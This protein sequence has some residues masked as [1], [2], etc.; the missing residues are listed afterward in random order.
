MADQIAIRPELPIVDAASVT[1]LSVWFRDRATSAAST[2][3]SIRYRVDCLTNRKNVIT[4]TSIA[5]S[6]SATIQ[7]PGT[8]N[9]IIDTSNDS[10]TRQLLVEIDTGLSTQTRNAATWKLKNNRIYEVSVTF[11]DVLQLEPYWP[12]DALESAL[13]IEH[14]TY[15]PGHRF[16]YL[17]TFDVLDAHYYRITAAEQSAGVT[18]V[19][20]QYE[21]DRPERLGAVSDNS[22]VCTT[23]FQNIVTTN[24]HSKVRLSQGNGYLVK[25][26][27]ALTGRTQIEGTGLEAT[28]VFNPVDANKRLFYGA[29]LDN[30]L[31]RDFAINANVGAAS[32]KEGLS[33]MLTGADPNTKTVR[34][35]VDNVYF[36]SLFYSI[37]RENAEHDVIRDCR[38]TNNGAVQGG[39][40]LRYAGYLN[41]GTI[42]NCD[43]RAQ[44][45]C[46]RVVA[47][48]SITLRNN[49]TEENGTSG[50]TIGPQFYFSDVVNAILVD[51]HYGEADRTGTGD[52]VWRFDNCG[53]VILRGMILAGDQG[54]TTY[55]DYFFRFV[56]PEADVLIESCVLSEILSGFV[57]V[58][59]NTNGKIVRM[60]GCTFIDGGS[61]I[62][63]YNSIMAKMSD[64]TAIELIDIPHTQ[65]YDPASIA[66]GD[67]VSTTYAVTGVVL[68]DEIKATFSLDLQGVALWAYVSSAGNVTAVFSNETAGVVD[69]GSGTLNTFVKKRST[70]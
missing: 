69:L 39:T 65:T 24:L 70:P 40:A 63:A 42:E 21:A 59:T 4:W 16:R 47:G 51:G 62:T 58:D 44:D 35:K 5:A 3:S 49:S 18:P 19:S 28:I 23:A 66:D 34:V 6:S 45:L 61:A 14:Y 7:I 26:E 50:G 53:P 11:D 27:V 15:P 31:F 60:R 32:G 8:S 12:A 68:G 29:N 22:T 1:N 36:D 56:T 43:F 41:H 52:G 2:P 64:A 17:D 48:S 46:L 30:I 57:K 67:R 25:G 33:F 10:E 37:N 54:G 13:T 9:A 55:S 20:L 38:F